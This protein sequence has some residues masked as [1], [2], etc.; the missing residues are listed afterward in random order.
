MQ[1]AAQIALAHAALEVFVVPLGA[2]GL[3]A[4]DQMAVGVERR[5]TRQQQ[6]GQWEQV[7]HAGAAQVHLQVH[8]LECPGIVENALGP[9]AQAARMGPQL[10]RKACLLALQVQHGA[11]EA[12][13]LDRGLGDAAGQADAH[14]IRKVWTGRPYKAVQACAHCHLAHAIAPAHQ[15]AAQAQLRH[16]EAPARTGGLGALES[17]VVAAVLAPRKDQVRP[18]E[19][20]MVQQH[21][22][23]QQ[24]PQPQAGRGAGCRG[25][26]GGVARGRGHFFVGQDDAVAVD[27]GRGRAGLRVLVL[28][29]VLVR[30]LVLRLS[31]GLFLGFLLGQAALVQLVGR[32]RQGW[33]LATAL[34][35]LLLHLP[36]FGLAQRQLLGLDSD[37]R[38]PVTPALV[39]RLGPVPLHPQVAFNREMPAGAFTDP[40]IDPG[41]GAIPVIGGNQDHDQRQQQHQCRDHPHEDAQPAAARRAGCGLGCRRGGAVGRC[42]GHGAGGR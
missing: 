32:R 29:F 8:A 15:A 40:L 10:D 11:D 17:P 41:P 28:A 35:R 3:Q 24:R 5:C 42:V 23:A 21:V 1:R 6:A 33:Q 12:L 31:P 14:A 34:G 19:L 13:G 26:G 37:A 16:L 38:N 25:H 18:F 9:C 39:Q 4:A 27:T 30:A 36:A 7:G 22:P 2:A 20:Q